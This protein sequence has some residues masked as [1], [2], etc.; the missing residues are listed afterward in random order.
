MNDATLTGRRMDH[1]TRF[2]PSPTTRAVEEESTSRHWIFFLGM[3]VFLGA[4]LVDRGRVLG[5]TPGTWGTAILLVCSLATFRWRG[6]D[7]IVWIVVGIA[8]LSLGHVVFR[9]QPLSSAFRIVGPLAMVL[10]IANQ[11]SSPK[12]ASGVLKVFVLSG[13]VIAGGFYLGLWDRQGDRS[14]FLM[15]NRSQIAAHLVGAAVA[16]LFLCRQ[17]ELGPRLRRYWY[18]L[19]L[20]LAI[21]ILVTASRRGAVALGASVLVYIVLARGVTRGII[22]AFG[23]AAVSALALTAINPDQ[24]P[25]GL[26]KLVERFGRGDDL[27][28][29]LLRRSMALVE[30]EPMA[31]YGIGATDDPMWLVRVGLTQTRI[32]VEPVAPH[33]GFLTVAL[34]GGLPFL[35][36][37]SGFLAEAG[38]RVASLATTAKTAWGR[39]AA[40]L[41][42][43]LLTVQLVAVAVSGGPYWKLG[44]W[45][46]GVALLMVVAGRAKEADYA[47]SSPGSSSGA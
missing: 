1:A 22:G 29:F 47:A 3:A 8:G 43:T 10:A 36:L 20:L 19:P 35:A 31:G 46:V 38:R 17:G 39:E 12:L 27:R 42:A 28:V 11:K 16:A 24:L 13:V 9:D 44:W 5:Q 32:T 15:L 23:L 21:P 33:N 40:G 2:V 41:G 37:F 26:S 7:L 34:Q 14:D 18:L 45:M 25:E 6:M 30:S 4:T